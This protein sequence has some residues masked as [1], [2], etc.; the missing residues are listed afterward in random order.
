MS[1]S[2]I[3]DAGTS[4]IRGILFDVN[5]QI[6]HIASQKYFMDV[7]EDGTAI[8]KAEHYKECLTRIMK[9]SAGWAANHHDKINRIALTAGRS[10]VLAVDEKGNALGPIMMWY[11]KRPQK[12]CD[13]LNDRYGD[14]IYSITGMYA[15]PMFSAPKM[16]WL[17]ENEPQIY[18]QSY[19]LVGI[20]DY[21]I[22]L[23]TGEW[24]TDL[25][26]ASR[27]NL[28][29]LNR[30]CW[31]EEMLNIF[32]I[33]RQKLCRLVLPG[34]EVG[35]LKSIWNDDGMSD[36]VKVYTAGGDQQCAAL[37]QGLVNAEK[38]GINNGTASYVTACCR[39]RMRD[40]DSVVHVNK[41]IIDGS[42]MMEASNMATGSVYDWMRKVFFDADNDSYSI[43][44]INQALEKSKPGA[45]GIIAWPYLAGK[46]MPDWDS[47][48]AGG[49][50]N[51][52][53]SSTRENIVR[54]FLEAL[55]F[56]VADCYRRIEG[57]VGKP[58]E[59]QISGGL[60]KLS[61]FNQLLANVLN[62]EVVT[63]SCKE[64]TGMGAYIAMLLGCG[65]LDEENIDQMILQEKTAVYKPE[66]EQV[67]LYEALETKRRKAEKMMPFGL[68]SL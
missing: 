7:S 53:L 2:L 67:A 42:W 1:D 52:K 39:T 10:S 55:I 56:E 50:M 45:D 60:S 29:D 46:G 20:Q 62:R 3:I 68:I 25:T 18:E 51:L 47:H 27:T 33:D 16:K 28:L 58:K 49:L 31:S 26:F 14:V 61:L 11:D 4:S 5:H 8:Q 63:V 24:V 57:M 35:T 36:L 48:K 17:K 6:V 22:F 15:R 41:G 44:A 64:T 12:L 30:N 40:D 23:L 54:A 65:E 37:G 66:K 19:K 38:I 32:G 13:W 21:L 34:S 43:Q 9:E 59:I